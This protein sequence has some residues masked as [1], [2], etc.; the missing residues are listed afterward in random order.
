ME[1]VA[2]GCAVGVGGPN[3]GGR[4]RTRAAVNGR[5]RDGAIGMAV[6]WVGG[7]L[8]LGVA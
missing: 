6:V 3:W 2:G 1:E 7:R 4:R 8:A 5:G